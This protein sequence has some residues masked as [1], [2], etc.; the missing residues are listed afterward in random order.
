MGEAPPS[1]S[2]YIPEMKRKS[3]MGR[4]LPGR[5]K[6]NRLVDDG[7]TKTIGGTIRCRYKDLS[8]KPPRGRRALPSPP[9]PNKQIN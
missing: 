8:P 9:P 3:S 4:L 5:M 6:E 2:V 1:P 7:V